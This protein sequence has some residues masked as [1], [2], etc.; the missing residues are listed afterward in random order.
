MSPIGAQARLTAIAYELGEDENEY[1]ELPGRAA[2]LARF[3]M[4]DDPT[5][6]G[7]GRYRRTRR[8]VRHLAVASARKTLAVAE[9]APGEVGMVIL[10]STSFPDGTGVHLDYC[11][12]VLGELGLLDAFTFGMTLNRCGTMLGALRMAE[13]A[14][15]SRRLDN[16]LVISADC[17]ADEATRLQNYAL[18]SDAAS[19]CLVTASGVAGH[20]ILHAGHAAQVSTINDTGGA[21]AADANRRM[22]RALGEDARLF[23]RVFHDNLFLPIVCMREQMAG[24]SQRQL[25][26]DNIVAIGHCFSSDPLI[27]FA[28]HGSRDPLPPGSVVGLFS[29]TPGLRSGL[30]LRA[31]TMAVTGIESRSSAYAQEG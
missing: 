27:N 15:A 2:A 28:T 29:G 5:L 22:C 30:V 11:N 18:F 6:W 10:C 1:H 23:K 26:L 25:F 24:F 31:G 16:V 14:I 4:V 12:L 19:S 17:V 13:I 21:L 9:I 20:D 8:D 3:Q 7:W